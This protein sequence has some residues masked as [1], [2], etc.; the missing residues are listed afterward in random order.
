VIS[1]IPERL[2][3][4]AI[5][6]G[7]KQVRGNP[8]LLATLF[9][10]LTD[11]EFN[12]IVSFFSK[13]P[14]A[15]SLNYP[16]ANLKVPA[17]CILLKGEKESSPFMGD[18]MGSDQVEG[19]EFSEHVIDSGVFS[20]TLAGP[21]TKLTGTYNIRGVDSNNSV[22][23]NYDDYL[24]LISLKLDVSNLKMY[25][26]SGKGKGRAFEVRAI[27]SGGY[28]SLED[29]TAYNYLDSTSIVD[30]RSSSGGLAVGEPQKVFNPG[31]VVT[32]KGAFYETTI[33][34]D[35]LAASQEEVSYLYYVTKAIIYLTRASLEGQGLININISGQDMAHRAE[36]I[37]D[38]IFNRVLS[39]TFN[40]PFSILIED[41]ILKEFLIELC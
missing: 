35:V 16:R 25:V 15:V 23:F 20:S 21:A 18:F 29:K 17:I 33:T 41:D 39:L 34:L 26:T 12:R 30:F 4:Q 10:N 38:E 31:T 5:A 14:I 13:T 24:E 19:S 3:E 27:E 28:V 6:V 32:R 40:N 37:P 22:F 2:I 11:P 7:L 1:A 36:F 9:Q 8:K